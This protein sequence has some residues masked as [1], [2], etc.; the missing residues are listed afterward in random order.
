M[1][2]KT[3]TL[4]TGL[5]A[6]LAATPALAGRTFVDRARVL[7]VIPV[8]ETVDVNDPVEECWN[9]PVVH[10]VTEYDSY[11]P[12][13]TGAILGGALGNQFGHG[14]G[15]KVATA[16]GVLLGAS[17]AHDLTRSNRHHHRYVD[18]ERRCRTVNRY[19]TEERLTGYKVKYRYAGHT[20]TTHT[21]R[22]PG[23]HIRVRVEVSP[24]HSY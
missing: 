15:R 19:T 17:V 3:L 12:E 1:N 24:V 4:M 21:K 8:Y 5:V 20:F 2:L 6:A 13:I 23:R 16:A 11:T 22:R 10:D 7:K 9:A 18:H 14:D